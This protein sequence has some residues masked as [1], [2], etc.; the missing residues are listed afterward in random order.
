MQISAEPRL[1]ERAL[2]PLMAKIVG[3][4]FEQRNAGPGI[5]R[6]GNSR[7]VVERQLRLQGFGGGRDDGAFAG[8]K[9]RGQIGKGFACSGACFAY[10]RALGR[11]FI[12]RPFEE[13][14]D[15]C[16]HLLLLRSRTKSIH[17]SSD[18][19]LRTKQ[20]TRGHMRRRVGGGPSLQRAL[21]AF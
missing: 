18:R 17:R 21:G 1:T 14:L 8:C 12:P 19:P 5:Q 11:T 7:D 16:G 20:I 15:A 9:N 2:E 3:A 10:Q 13:G 4:P 6:P